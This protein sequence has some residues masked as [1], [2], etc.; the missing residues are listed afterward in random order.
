[1]FNHIMVGSNDLDRSE[2]FYNAVLGVLGAGPPLRNH[3]ACTGRPAGPS[4]P[5][6]P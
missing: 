6:R 2:A 3:S 5:A 1:M 4:G